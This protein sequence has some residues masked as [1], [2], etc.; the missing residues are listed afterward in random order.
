MC[1]IYFGQ[2]YCLS[3]EP[4]KD[5]PKKVLTPLQKKYP[6]DFDDE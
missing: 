1:T 4:M 2:D 6:I 5:E 3:D